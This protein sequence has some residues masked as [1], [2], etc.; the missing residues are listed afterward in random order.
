MHNIVIRLIRLLLFGILTF[1]I[2]YNSTDKYISLL[3]IFILF[4]IFDMYFPRVKIE[5][6]TYLK[7]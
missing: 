4:L 7:K 5:D 6:K 1:I 2:L 3:L